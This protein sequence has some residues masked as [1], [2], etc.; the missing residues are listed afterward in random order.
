M[1]LIEELVKKGILEKEK[2]ASLEEE[3][4]TSGKKEEELI[5]E[6]GIVSEDFL[7]ELKSGYLKI[8]FKKIRPE[9]IP[10]EI[11]EQIP[12]E[13][14]RYYQMVPLAKKENVLEVGMVYPEDL[15]SQEALSFLARRGKFTYQVFLITET[16]F[17]NILDKYKTPKRE[18]GKALEELE[19]E[20]KGRK[21]PRSAEIERMVE[22]APISKMVAVILK[23]GVE[24]EASDIHIEPLK[25][26]LRVRFRTLGAL[27]P[28]IFLPIKI[29]PAVISRIKILANLR[30]DETR[31]PQDGRF[32][33]RV[34]DRDI[35]FRIS[36]FPTTLGE[37]VAI[38][39]LDPRVG[40]KKFEEL[41]LSGRNFEVVKA[42]VEK[43]YGMIL[44]TGPTGCGKTTTQYAILQILNK[45]GVNIVTLEDPVEYLIEGINQSQVR[46]EIGY[47]FSR[48]L[49]QIVRQ[50][51]DI[52]MVG[53]IR[54][55][56]TAALT[57]HAALTGHIVLST[58]HTS[59][60]LGVIPRLIDLGVQ[61]FL[62]PSAL[63]IAT[64]Q[65][66]ARK[67][68][69]NCKRKVK[70]KKETRD[71]ILKE[72]DK[73]PEKVKKEIKIP[74]PLTIFEPVGCRD[75]HNTGFS[76]RIALFE[77]LEM[78]P[79][80]A[81]IILRETS[82]AKILEEATR[83]GMLTMKQDGILKVLDGITTIEEVL[84]VAEEK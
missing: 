21:I 34:E 62:L 6:K 78:T 14:A 15:A 10:M 52:I 63:S 64:A 84:R 46:P 27:H 23:Y 75:C 37:K 50:D 11:L 58:L 33:T 41:G 80:L 48:G 35:D 83:Q 81:E 9:E 18:V 45:E 60:V 30:I 77:I 67:L 49:R 72:I 32:S 31:I 29:L 26:K 57:T 4:K 17:K 19:T 8:P 2:A 20:L 12:E 36:T 54:D 42:A 28:S 51:P 47:D 53:E 66:L 40:L 13:T 79:Q 65:R 1:P 68:C 61:P 70:P 38:R 43:P 74:E 22:E 56:E 59:N 7:F 55:S 71:L 69:Q 25:D 44:S 3:L 5:L 82:E 39:V 73:L 16:N 24:G 76:G